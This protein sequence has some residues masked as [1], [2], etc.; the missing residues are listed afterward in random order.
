MGLGVRVRVRVRAWGRFISCTRTAS[1]WTG[2]VLYP[3]MVI[4]HVSSHAPGQPPPGRAR[5]RARAR[6]R[7]RPRARARELGS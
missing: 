2:H 7:N 5:I 1:T 6:A 4:C 3:Y